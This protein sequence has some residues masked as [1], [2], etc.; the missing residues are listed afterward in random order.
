MKRLNILSIIAALALAAPAAGSAVN[1]FG[2]VNKAGG[3]MSAMALRRIGSTE[4]IPLSITPP[5]GAT[6]QVPFQ[7]PDCAFDLRA[8]VAGVGQVTWGGLNLCDV[9]SVT[10]NRDQGGRA[11]VDYD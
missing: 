7:N 3:A 6:V 11:W 5:P 4:W 2:I 8:N 9:K 10:L 1:G